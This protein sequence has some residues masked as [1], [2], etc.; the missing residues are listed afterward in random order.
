[1]GSK[2]LWGFTLGLI[3]G[4]LLAPDKG[5]ETR[6]RISRK[7]SDLKEKFDDFIDSVSEKL[8]SFK[9]E[10]EDL[11]KNA[12]TEARSFAGGKGGVL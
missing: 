10:T 7:A 3:A 2:L 4:L 5:S 12:K 1:M 8:D 9:N 11:A 6:K